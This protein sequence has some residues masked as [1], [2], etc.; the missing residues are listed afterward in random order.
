MSATRG[1]FLGRGLEGV[2][3]G[4]RTLWL[5]ESGVV[6]VIW[7]S[8]RP[9]GVSWSERAQQCAHVSCGSHLTVVGTD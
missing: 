4:P 7:S 6:R 2:S 1:R 8:R 9:Y 3:M 5:R